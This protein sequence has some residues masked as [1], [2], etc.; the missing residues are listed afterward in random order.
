MIDW[1]IVNSWWLVLIVFIHLIVWY[2]E[3]RKRSAK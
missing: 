2:V 3:L 1:S